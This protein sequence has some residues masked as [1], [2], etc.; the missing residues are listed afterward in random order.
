MMARKAKA[1]STKQP[2]IREGTAT[3]EIRS[4][5]EVFWLAFKS[6]SADDQGAFLERLLNDPEF[7]E[8]IADSVIAIEREAE[9]S[10][11]Y[12]E[13]EAELRREGRL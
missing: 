6:L 2:M 10:R 11:P 5:A 7:F 3:Y 8:D 4:M 1:V 9:P 13:F 12:D